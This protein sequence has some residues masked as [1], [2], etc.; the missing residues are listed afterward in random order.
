M[1]IQKSPKAS[2][3]ARPRWVRGD[4]LPFSEH[5]ARELHAAG[6][7]VSACLRVPGSG[8]SVRLYDTESLD[9]YLEQLASNSAGG[10]PRHDG[11]IA[12]RKK[13]GRLDRHHPASPPNRSPRSETH[14]TNNGN[15]RA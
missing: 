15:G 7:L 8:R 10:L 14:A 4:Q 13:R 11:R 9:A 6:L 5:F 1:P 3:G 2:K 12:A